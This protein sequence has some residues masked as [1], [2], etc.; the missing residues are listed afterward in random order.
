MAEEIKFVFDKVK[1]YLDSLELKDSKE[2]GE[3][4]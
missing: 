4:S 1:S 2:Y 3:F